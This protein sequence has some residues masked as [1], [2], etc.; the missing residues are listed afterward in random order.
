M[1]A[2]ASSNLPDRPIS[3]G[4]TDRLIIQKSIE[5]N[6]VAS[7]FRCYTE[8]YRAEL[9]K[10]TFSSLVTAGHHATSA[11]VL[12]SDYEWIV[13][14]CITV[15]FP[16][17]YERPCGVVVGAISTQLKH[18]SITSTEFSPI[19]QLQASPLC[20]CAVRRAE[21][22]SCCQCPVSDDI[23]A[24][25]LPFASEKQ[26][27]MQLGSYSWHKDSARNEVTATVTVTC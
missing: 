12:F 3:T 1:L 10:A 24:S 25:L 4:L 5:K 14:L 21:E 19:R 11:A 22:S 7:N 15:C 9:T 26:D 16:A 20:A 13:T 27:N 18:T 8:T 6:G 17:Y 23:T 2:S